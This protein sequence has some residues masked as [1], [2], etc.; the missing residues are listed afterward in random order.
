MNLAP[1]EAPLDAAAS[2]SGQASRVD[3]SPTAHALTRLQQSRAG[4]QRALTETAPS[5]QPSTSAGAPP[6]LADVL[7]KLR[8]VPA[9]NL[10]LDAIASW[11]SQQPAGILLQ[12]G[13]TATRTLI[14][15]VAQRHPVALVVCALAFGGLII[16]TRPW[17][18]LLRP[19]AISRWLPRFATGVAAQIP[20]SV[21]LS[22]L[23]TAQS[24][25]TPDTTT[26]TPQ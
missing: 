7:T 20:L 4:I 8:S 12:L 26:K 2:G 3:S 11:W 16:W 9:A 14:K 10:L 23:R 25:S 18:W 6:L 1:A 21:W 19:T 24:P 17:R 22:L 13:T 15:P 5:A